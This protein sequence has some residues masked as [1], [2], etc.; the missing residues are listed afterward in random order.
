MGR[1]RGVFA[2]K[3][4]CGKPCGRGDLDAARL[5][6]RPFGRFAGGVENDR[7]SYDIREVSG[8][9]AGEHEDGAGLEDSVQPLRFAH[10]AG[11]VLRA[12]PIKRWLQPASLAR[13]PTGSG[14]LKLPKFGRESARPD[15]APVRRSR[16]RGPSRG[17]GPISPTKALARENARFSTGEKYPGRVPS[18]QSRQ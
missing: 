1:G 7:K 9:C 14:R 2:V 12:S 13:P 11:H 3:P 5:R 10:S 16:K 15:P 18:G 4:N 8:F 6:A 17:A